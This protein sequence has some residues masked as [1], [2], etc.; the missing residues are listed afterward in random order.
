MFQK[1]NNIKNDNLQKVSYYSTKKKKII[2]LFIGFFGGAIMLIIFLSII[3]NIFFNKIS[4]SSTLHYVCYII[5]TIIII[6]LIVLF[7]RINRKFISIGILIS[8]LVAVSLFMKQV[9]FYKD[10]M[11][12]GGIIK[13][14]ILGQYSIYDGNSDIQET[15]VSRSELETVSD[16]HMGTDTPIMTIV[17]F[18]DFSCPYCFIMHRVLRDF[19]MENATKVQLIFRD[20]P[21]EE[22][23]NRAMIANCAFEQGKFW[24]MHDNLFLYQESF[25][26]NMVNQFLKEAEIDV[27]KFNACRSEQRY[28]SEIEEDLV[29][30]LKAGMSG[31]PT[32]FINGYKFAG[33]IPRTV[34]DQILVEIEKENK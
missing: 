33:V 17:E 10:A 19:I 21:L 31:T 3:L 7:F 28:K 29:V 24:Q 14:T 25:N 11:E 13:N 5:A 34:L 32:L 26:E 27:D 20:F 22:D 8:L 30:G 1:N 15:D 6:I 9:Y 4:I 23:Y 18:G 16:P 12:T 2:D